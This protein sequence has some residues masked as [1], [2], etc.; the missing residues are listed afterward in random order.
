MATVT[1]KEL[2]DRIADRVQIKRILVKRILQS[3]LDKVTDELSKENRLEFR[4]F[5]VFDTMTRAARIAQNPQTL[6]KV[7]VPAKRKVRFK[8]GRN[9]KQ[10][11]NEQVPIPEENK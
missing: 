3:F 1:K 4:E 10:K 8:M 7:Q 11:L 6:E 2:V 5:G 9:M